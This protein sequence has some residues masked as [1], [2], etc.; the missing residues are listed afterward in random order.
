MKKKRVRNN[1]IVIII[2]ILVIVLIDNDKRFKASEANHLPNADYSYYYKKGIGSQ[3]LIRIYSYDQSIKIISDNEQAFGL[4]NSH[5]TRAL[6]LDN[7]ELVSARLI[8]ASNKEHHLIGFFNTLQI[9]ILSVSDNNGKPL[10]VNL[11]PIEDTLELTSPHSHLQLFYIENVPKQLYLL[12]LD[13]HVNI[14][15]EHR[16]TRN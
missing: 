9:D 13:K 16:Y 14:I 3:T 1:L 11:V 8:D 15:Y 10:K 7:N 6:R 2:I 5:A 12:G 4:M